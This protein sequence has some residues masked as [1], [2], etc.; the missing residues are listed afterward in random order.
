MSKPRALHPIRHCMLILLLLPFGEAAAMESWSVHCDPSILRAFSSLD[1]EIWAAGR[2]GMVRLLPDTGES[3]YITTAEGLPELDLVDL[4][5]LD[6]QI[7][8]AT[9]SEGLLRYRPDEAQ[10]WFRYQALPQGLADDALHCLAAGPDGALWYGSE[11]G[12]GRIDESAGSHQIWT[13]LDGLENDQVLSLALLGDTL[14]VGTAG[15]LYRM[16]PGE[17]PYSLDH[18]PGGGIASLAVA[19]DSLWVLDSSGNLFRDRP[20][21]ENWTELSSPVPGLEYKAMRSDGASLFVSL[22]E[23]GYG[24]RQDRVFSY[25]PGAG[26]T[27]LSDGLPNDYLSSSEGGLLY[28]A[29]NLGEDGEIWLGG[30]INDG[31]LGPGMLRRDAE[32][33]THFPL[34]DRPIGSEVKALRLGPG[35]NLWCMATFSG[36]RLTGA[37]WTRYHSDSG[38]AWLPRFGLDLLE[39][40]EGWVWFSRYSH[41]LGRIRLSDGLE[42]IMIADGAFIIRMAEDAAGNRW[43]GLDGQGLDCFTANDEWLHF[44]SGDADLPGLVLDGVAPMTGNRIAFLFRGVGLRVWD[45]RGSLDSFGDDLWWTPEDNDGLLENDTQFSSLTHDDQGGLWVGQTNGLVR[46][47]PDGGGYTARVRLG[48][49]SSF[50]DGLLSSTVNDVVADH[51]GGAWVATSLGLARVNL[52]IEIEDDVEYWNWTIRNWTNEAGRKAAGE[53]LFGQEVLAPLPNARITRLAA[54]PEGVGVWV[55]TG[56]GLARL[57]VLA[58]PPGDPEAVAGA[59]VYP[60]PIRSDLGHT[61]LRLGGVEEAVNLRVYNLEGQ[62][63][64]DMGLVEPGELAWDLKTRFDCNDCYAVSGVYIL[65]LEIRGR[66]STRRV[67]LVK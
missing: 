36:A 54:S 45:H 14:L 34:A 57:D 50:T 24:G 3:T 22:G 13:D 27:D 63:V 53:E 18:A 31:G 9:S 62:L 6:G 21:G 65:R 16:N 60:N 42:E 38:F 49:K 7:W 55:G 8:V 43:F 59:W 12:Y 48:A 44:D 1:G 28:T 33:W 19:A 46:V 67:V 58:D 2:G 64:K 23:S 15:G 41:A 26:W 52:D 4:L 10:P 17:N 25:E 56:T 37:Q 39:D 47:I 61:G 40:S 35:G 11:S 20:E 29:L 32:G 5:A 51:E 66:V 30:I